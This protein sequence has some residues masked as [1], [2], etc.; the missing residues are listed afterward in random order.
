MVVVSVSA[1]CCRFLDFV[2]CILFLFYL[3]N[4]F[5][6]LNNVIC[7]KVKAC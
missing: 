2:A 3:D 5:Y 1:L 4:Y 7:P 6:K